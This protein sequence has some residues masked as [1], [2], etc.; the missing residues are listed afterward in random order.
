MMWK[1]ALP[2]PR[3]L[4]LRKA[5][6]EKEKYSP[7]AQQVLPEEAAAAE[8]EEE[9]ATSS[10]PIACWSCI[11][12]LI[13]IV[14][15]SLGV[16]AVFLMRFKP[17][18][19]NDPRR[20]VALML[21][22]PDP[23][24]PAA[25]SEQLGQKSRSFKMISNG[26]CKE[27]GLHPILDPARCE[28]AA[29]AL[30]LGDTGASFTSAAGVPEGCYYKGGA[31]LFF[32]INP[33]N[34]GV[35]S[36]LPKR[37]RPRTNASSREPL[38]A[39]PGGHFHKISEEGGT[40]AGQWPGLRVISDSVQCRTA[41]R[42]LGIL[43]MSVGYTVA[44]GAV[45]LGCYALNGRELWMGRLGA[46]P[47]PRHPV[48]STWSGEFK[49][50]TKGACVDSGLLPIFQKETCEEAGRILGFNDRN[51]SYAHKWGV[52]Q[53]CYVH[54]TTE[55]NFLWIGSLETERA[56]AKKD[57]QSS[58]LSREPICRAE[59]NKTLHYVKIADNTSC[60]EKGLAPI[61]Q[62][63]IC[64]R[65]AR[66]LRLVDLE[67]TVT[68]RPGVP[69][70]CYYLKGLELWL[71]TGRTSPTP[72]PAPVPR[73]SRR[74]LEPLCRTV[75]GSDFRKVGNWNRTCQDS[76]LVPILRADDCWTAARAWKRS[77]GSRA[78][79]ERM[80]VSFTRDPQL[81]QGCFLK[82]GQEVWMRVHLMIDSEARG[83]HQLELH[84]H[85]GW[86][87]KNGSQV[88]N[89][90]RDQICSGQADEK[91]RA[92]VD[93]GSEIMHDDAPDDAPSRGLKVARGRAWVRI[94]GVMC[95]L[96]PVHEETTAESL[97]IVGH[98]QDVPSEQACRAA[99]EVAR[100][101][102]GV[103]TWASHRNSVPCWLVQRS[104]DIDMAACSSD[105]GFTLWMQDA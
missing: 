8:E 34:K 77:L 86:D 95:L 26:S 33:V 29:G 62:V 57:N 72:T 63:H 21:P 17:D 80:E 82:N 16:G 10:S 83:D 36:I 59:R 65:A 37:T 96:R 97:S 41:A 25:S 91:Q 35:G 19:V 94:P 15:A 2:S 14:S 104:V 49:C 67:A 66:S 7:L 22:M 40:C 23:R 47:A 81:P 46:E 101:C 32:G 11:V 98:R 85:L 55:G 28:E 70:G 30:L 78:G 13:L 92:S 38:C 99:C 71:G 20:T 60:E 68:S 56:L 105:A 103:Q 18:L 9:G 5:P 43:N 88:P 64:Q 69:H 12:V 1:S 76:G 39:S 79:E 52:P 53:G 89:S 100:D 102:V 74:S 51:V 45:P 4:E 61:M 58:D 3:V 90:A 50:I 24:T 84:S 87:G 93:F 27:V 44:G 48:C 73:T 6:D 75:D 31:K 54:V 42:H